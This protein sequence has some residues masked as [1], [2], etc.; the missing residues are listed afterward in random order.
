MKES[1][2]Y[3]QSAQRR[4]QS[5]GKDSRREREISGRH[6]RV[7]KRGNEVIIKWNETISSGDVSIA[8]LAYREPPY[9]IEWISLAKQL[10]EVR[11]HALAMPSA[12][13]EAI[14]ADME[15]GDEIY[16]RKVNGLSIA[17][18]DAM[19]PDP[20]AGYLKADDMK[21]IN[22]MFRGKSFPV[23]ER[24]EHFRQ[25]TDN[26]QVL[27][28]LTVF[29]IQTR[30]KPGTERHAPNLRNLKEN[31]HAYF[32]YYVDLLLDPTM[33]HEYQRNISTALM[34]GG[35]KFRSA[36]LAYLP[37]RFGITQSSAT[38][39]YKDAMYSNLPEA[40]WLKAERNIFGKGSKDAYLVR[41][42]CLTK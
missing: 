24:F 39:I 28:P 33:E 19:E 21:R 29:A 35:P 27:D 9:A 17:D 20:E 42:P 15:K 36:L 12:N 13:K 2:Y 3:S 30:A 22:R 11:T 1:T 41:H 16:T 4:M 10:H 14:Q 6:Q 32:D 18:I 40:F 5:R 25:S 23:L 34:V 8:Q 31:I 26:T 38:K 7:V 37:A